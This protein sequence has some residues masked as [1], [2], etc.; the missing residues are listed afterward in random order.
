MERL[1]SIR[2]LALAAVMLGGSACGTVTG[3]DASKCPTTIPEVS[4]QVGGSPEDWKAIADMQGAWIFRSTVEQ[5]LDGP[6][7]GRLDTMGTGRLYSGYYR[8][9]RAAWYV[10]PEPAQPLNPQDLTK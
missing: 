2:R 3:K 10:C 1:G 5:T 9:A 7:I 6:S 4:R 8:P